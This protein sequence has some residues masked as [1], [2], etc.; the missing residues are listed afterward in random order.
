MPSIISKSL[1]GTGTGMAD[2]FDG[3]LNGKQSGGG[4]G[5]IGEGVWPEETPESG[6]GSLKFER[7]VESD[8]PA[9]SLAADDRWTFGTGDFTVEFSYWN[10]T[11]GQQPFPRI[12]SIGEYPNTV[13]GLSIE[14]GQ[15]LLWIE[16]QYYTIANHVDENWQHFVIMR[17][18]NTFYA[19]VNGGMIWNTTRSVSLGAGALTIGAEA[20]DKL[21]TTMRGC[22][23]GFHIAKIALYD[24]MEEVDTFT[25]PSALMEL[26]TLLL[27]SSDDSGVSTLPFDNSG[28]GLVTHS[29][30][31][32]S[33]L[34]AS[35]YVVE[36]PQNRAFN[37]EDRHEEIELSNDDRTITK[38]GPIAWRSARSTE[39]H[40]KGRYYF[41]ATFTEF[42]GSYIAIGVG[43]PDAVLDQYVGYSNKGVGLVSDGSVFINSSPTTVTGAISEGDI[44][45]V[46]VNIAL[47]KIWFSVNGGA[48]NP[49]L[50]GVQNPETGE[51]GV[52]YH[53][54]LTY[55]HVMGSLQKADDS[56]T[57]NFGYGES[58][59]YA[60]PDTFLPWSSGQ[61][62]V[63][64]F[65]VGVSAGKVSSDLTDFPLFINL[66]NTMPAEFWETTD[67]YGYGLRAYDTENNRLP[68]DVVYF[69]REN[70]VGTVFV[71]TGITT[72]G[73]SVR[74]NTNG[75]GR[76]APDASYGQHEVWEDYDV[77]ALLGSDGFNRTG[78]GATRSAGDPDWFN[79]TVLHT[80]TEDPHQGG[81]FD[82]E[83]FYIVDTNAIYKFDT[84]WNLIATNADPVGASG[85]VG[86]NHCGDPCIKDGLLYVPI[87]YY[88]TGSSSVQH[89]V[90]FDCSD[91]SYVGKYSLSAN[92][93][94][95]SSICFCP[96][97]GNFYITDYIAG[98][99]WKWSQ[100]FVRQGE[101]VINGNGTK[102]QGIEWWQNRFWVVDDNLDEVLCVDMAG[103]T[104]RQ[105]NTSTVNG[106]FGQ[107]VSGNM[108]G[109]FTGPRGLCV[110][111]DPSA[112]NS[113]LTE[114]EV[115][116]GTH[117]FAN[118]GYRE[119]GA[120]DRC[121]D[122]ETTD[123][124]VFTMGVTGTI[125]SKGVNRCLVSYHD[126]TTGGTPN[127]RISVSY[128]NSVTQFGVWDDLNTWLYA[129][130]P[131]NPELDEPFR[132]NVQYN[133]TTERKFFV[134][135][136]LAATSGAISAHSGMDRLRLFS[137]DETYNE[138]WHGGAGFVYLRSGLLSDA[139][140]QAEYDNFFNEN[141]VEI[142]N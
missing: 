16:G 12:F 86:A 97:D 121:V 60:V 141:F 114:Y 2:M 118:L 51:G 30:E 135:G 37:P 115:S 57:V 55:G 117:M 29:L 25:E 38:I 93:Q 72:T 122:F 22:V 6:F 63:F 108:E 7:M 98:K 59:A 64:D 107:A 95:V 26:T 125:S 87:E 62:Q 24:P 50:G 31:G 17:S 78:K 140:L 4:G 126:F 88:E 10:V 109:I 113:F 61:E 85:I 84:G 81:S 33:W 56:L 132:L 42:S 69:D 65:T 66:Q 131:F 73:V 9:Y 49:S 96:V 142:E 120:G 130:S 67:R 8:T 58:F 14:D 28:L 1:F 74:L 32:C 129:T 111:S 133:G 45:R 112:A 75:G 23:A 18:G 116:P 53:S 41:E 77:V 40:D 89:I 106:V 27:T 52:T 103:N 104:H 110:L 92:P 100:S 82:G 134:N 80:F 13:L 94:E 35:P 68:L 90:T 34:E 54:S 15:T 20:P 91:L 39:G 5:G 83:F 11:E 71:K 139:W 99:I 47:R 19:F 44:V 119:T 136:E 46:A 127:D 70:Q 79:G 76:V 36:I 101:L 128:S 3:I 102:Y 21:T 43:A 123:Y 138:K 48:W 124:T 105:P 137:E